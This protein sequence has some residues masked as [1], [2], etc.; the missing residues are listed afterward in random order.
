MDG[1]MERRSE[2]SG[3][4]ARR[5]GDMPRTRRRSGSTEAGEETEREE[6]EEVSEAA[7]GR[8]WNGRRERRC[9]ERDGW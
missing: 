7:V 2:E 9:S 1:G 5:A 8:K 4:S 3:P 6:S